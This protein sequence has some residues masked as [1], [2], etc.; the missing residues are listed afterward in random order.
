MHLFTLSPDIGQPTRIDVMGS[1]YGI[2]IS[3]LNNLQPNR[4][5]NVELLGKDLSHIIAMRVPLQAKQ[6]ID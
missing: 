1:G 4:R 3:L 2:T 6:T 5:D